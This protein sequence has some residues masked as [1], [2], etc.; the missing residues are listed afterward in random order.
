MLTEVTPSRTGMRLSEFMAYSSDDRFELIDGV[1]IP[2]MATIFVHTFIANLLAELINIWA[3]FG[4][5][6]RAFVEATFVLADTP[7]SDWVTGSRIPDVA[8]ISAERLQHYR[9]SVPDWRTRPLMLI[10]DLVIE[11]VSPNDKYTEII[12]KVNRY[13]Q[14]GVK[15]V[16]V[17]NPEQ[18][19]VV[20]YRAESHTLELLTELDT[21]SDEA[22]LPG[23][24]APLA[25][26]FA[27][28]T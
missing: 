5:A 10:P 21:L 28:E 26:L 11:V 24:A 17:V 27:D 19:Q 25:R 8:Y 6:G 13:L 2:K 15:R 23:F 20:V 12:D 14:D 4:G 9:A 22:L 18:R 3:Q 1:M 16:W 7:T